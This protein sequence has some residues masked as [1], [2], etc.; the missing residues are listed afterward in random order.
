MEEERVNRFFRENETTRLKNAF[1]W[2]TMQ[3]TRGQGSMFSSPLSRYRFTSKEFRGETSYLLCFYFFVKRVWGPLPLKTNLIP[4]IYSPQE[5][6]TQAQT[7]PR[8]GLF[9]H[10]W[11]SCTIQGVKLWMDLGGSN[12][13][14]LGNGM[15]SRSADT[16]AVFKN[17]K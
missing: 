2:R 1:C 9:L 16:L 12:S 4:P 5:P 11:L 13:S 14:I 10:E 3:I 7:Y 8:S 17:F 6:R 15:S